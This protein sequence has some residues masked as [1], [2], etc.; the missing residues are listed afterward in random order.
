LLIIIVH[1]TSTFIKARSKQNKRITY[2][3][4]SDVDEGTLSC[5]QVHLKGVNKHAAHLMYTQVHNDTTKRRFVNVLLYNVCSPDGGHFWYGTGAIMMLCI[6]DRAT[7]KAV[8]Y[9]AAPSLM[10]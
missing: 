8:I 3:I 4:F 9:T 5:K 2:T 6:G 1:T 7:F 10:V